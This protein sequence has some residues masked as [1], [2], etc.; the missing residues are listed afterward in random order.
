M[1]DLYILGTYCFV[2]NVVL[3]C[4]NCENDNLIFI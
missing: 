4:R 1:S 3:C 2:Y